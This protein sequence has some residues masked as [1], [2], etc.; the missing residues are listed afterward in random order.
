MVEVISFVATIHIDKE[1]VV[2]EIY[3]VKLLHIVASY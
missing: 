3:I 2:S 1:T